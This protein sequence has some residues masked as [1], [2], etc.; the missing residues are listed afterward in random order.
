MNKGDP[1]ETIDRAAEDFGMP[2][3][4]IA[5][6]DKVGLD[7]IVDVGSMMGKALKEPIPDI[8]KWINEVFKCAPSARPPSR[9][10]HQRT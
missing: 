5:L 6:A 8:P 4:P 1:P 3:R 9:L 7:I 10:Q 2:M